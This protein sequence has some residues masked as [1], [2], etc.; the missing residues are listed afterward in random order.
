MFRLGKS[1]K[2]TKKHRYADKSILYYYDNDAKPNL[3]TYE[4]DDTALDIEE[5]T[6][7]NKSR[8]IQCL[9]STDMGHHLSFEEEYAEDCASQNQPPPD[10]HPGGSPQGED[11][12]IPEDVRVGG[13]LTPIP[14]GDEENVDLT[15]E[16]F[17]AELMSDQPVGTMSPTTTAMK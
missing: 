14:E 2:N 17:Y 15:L 10:D 12:Y 8:F 16:T 3:K 6:G 5:I 9:L 7:S 13:N 4:T 1:V 11:Q